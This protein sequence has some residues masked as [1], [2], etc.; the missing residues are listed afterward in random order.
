MQHDAGI[1]DEGERLQKLKQL[2]VSQCGS[3]YELRHM[4]VVGAS[5]K[6]CYILG[7]VGGGTWRVASVRPSG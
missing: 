3:V 4:V 2:Q 1:R 5:G 7:A 6:S